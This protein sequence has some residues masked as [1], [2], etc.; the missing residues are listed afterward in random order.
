M[1][2][3]YDPSS[4]R[5][6]GQSYQR[7]HF[8]PSFVG[9]LDDGPVFWLSVPGGTVLY[10]LDLWCRDLVFWGL[11]KDR[12]LSYALVA[13]QREE[14]MRYVKK[15]AAKKE[16]QNGQV[17]PDI[18]ALKRWPCLWEH[19]TAPSYG[20]GEPAREKST[21]TFY[22]GA[23]GLSAVL[24][25]RDNAQA[26]FAAAGTLVGLLD[27]LEAVAANPKTTWREDRNQT[28]SSA[29]KKPTK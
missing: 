9:Y 1:A 28:G 17:I 2:W 14:I 20:E 4:V 5:L 25:D 29:R 15:Q 11:V 13:S 6:Q 19:L 21:I 26:C 8:C 23:Q 22:V 7:P 12:Y 10:G 3:S 24:N 16:T 27:A 18:E